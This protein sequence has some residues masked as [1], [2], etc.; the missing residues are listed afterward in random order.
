MSTKLKLTPRVEVELGCI[1]PLFVILI[2]AI[3]AGMFGGTTGR[4]RHC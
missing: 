3:A 1:V 2:A 4:D